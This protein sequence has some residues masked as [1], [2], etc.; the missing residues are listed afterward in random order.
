MT[1]RCW[2]CMRCQGGVLTV[3]FRESVPGLKNNWGLMP[4]AAC[5]WKCFK[6]WV[7]W[8]ELSSLS[9]TR[10]VFQKSVQMHQWG[11]HYVTFGAT[12]TPVLRRVHHRL[13]VSSPCQKAG[14]FILPSLFTSFLINIS[15]GDSVIFASHLIIIIKV[16][17]KPGIIHILTWMVGDHLLLICLLTPSVFH[18]SREILVSVS[19]LPEL[20]SQHQLLWCLVLM[21]LLLL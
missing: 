7:L 6:T 20:S 19:S 5:W 9:K 4:Q 18:P 15:H 12:A 16:F 2:E 1:L 14:E 11:L 13:P 17:L 8:K 21:Y 10:C 3:C